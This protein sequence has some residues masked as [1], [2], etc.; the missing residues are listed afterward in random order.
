MDFEYSSPLIQKINNEIENLFINLENDVDSPR[1]NLA[2]IL[3]F[4]N[5]QEAS[6]IDEVYSAFLKKKY[7]VPFFIEQSHNEFDFCIDAVGFFEN[8]IESRSLNPNCFTVAVL[9]ENT[10][11]DV[12]SFNSLLIEEIFNLKSLLKSSDCSKL[13]KDQKTV[14]EIGLGYLGTNRANR[15]KLLHVVGDYRKHFKLIGKY[16][17]VVVMEVIDKNF[18]EIKQTNGTFNLFS[19]VFYWNF[20]RK[21]QAPQFLHQTRKDRIY[22][23]GTVSKIKSDLTAKLNELKS[24]NATKHLKL[25]DMKSFDGKINIISVKYRTPTLNLN[26]N[27]S[28]NSEFLNCN[29]FSPPKKHK[30][31]KNE[32]KTSDFN[33]NSNEQNSNL[34]MT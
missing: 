12:E 28:Y 16:S 23:V 7:C 6:V 25:S 30:N 10:N 19:N 21:H 14:I 2:T 27:P 4:I 9:S 5:S 24:S 32:P 20:S 34:N 1:A 29:S 11:P 33:N 15:I 8:E 13:L 31:L 3:Q 18:N 26:E 22:F 17:N